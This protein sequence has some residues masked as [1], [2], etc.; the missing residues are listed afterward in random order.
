[1]RRVRRALL[2][3]EGRSSIETGVLS[4]AT[5]TQLSRRQKKTL[6]NIF[7]AS[8]MAVDKKAAHA[9]AL[10]EAAAPKS[11]TVQIREGGPSLTFSMTLG[12]SAE[13]TE[14]GGARPPFT[15]GNAGRRLTLGIV[16]TTAPQ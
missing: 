4:K 12:V 15:L 1:M 8:G 16:V 2:I 13:G 14:I 3:I 9:E 11:V 5:K 6:R 7:K 10:A